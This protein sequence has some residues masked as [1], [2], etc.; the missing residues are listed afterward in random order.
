M[1][2]YSKLRRDTTLRC[3]ITKLDGTNGYRWSADIALDSCAFGVLQDEIKN[4]APSPPS[5]PVDDNG[6]VTVWRII[7]PAQQGGVPTMGWVKQNP[8]DGNLKETEEQMREYT[9][10]LRDYEH[11]KG[12]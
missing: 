9:T 7:P 10:K 5:N 11:L 8:Q 6:Q 2:S 12:L 3:C 1:H 4:D